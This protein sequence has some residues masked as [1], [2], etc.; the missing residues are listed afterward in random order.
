MIKNILVSK[1]FRGSLIVML[2]SVLVNI[3]NYLYHLFMGRL[4]GPV[5]Y[6][7][8]SSLI[9]LTYFLGVPAGAMNLQI[10]KYV[11]QEKGDKNKIFSFYL[12]FIKKLFIVS[13]VIFTLLLVATPWFSGVLKA[14]T[15][16]LAIIV[17]ISSFLSIFVSFNQS[18]FQ[19]LFQFSW[20]SLTGVSQYGSKL[21]VGVIL[22]LLGTRI[23][24]AVFSLFISALIA[25][26]LSSLIL[27][28]EA[29]KAKVRINRSI[30][31][32][33]IIS[34]IVP[35]LLF[36]LSFTSLYSVDIILARYFLPA[37]ESG[38]YSALSVMGKSMFFAITPFASVM[39]PLV[40]RKQAEKKNY[41]NVFVFSFVAVLA[42]CVAIVIAY[43]LTPEF[44]INIFY[45]V[46]Y[47]PI[48]QYLSIFA[49]IF[50]FFSLAHLLMNY[51]FSINKTKVVA[52]Y[53]I[54]AVAQAIGFFIMHDSIIQFAQ[55]SLFVV[56]FLF[57]ALSLQYLANEKKKL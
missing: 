55:V 22:V 19:G 53:V 9:A 7:L 4:L 5:D 3:S 32:K 54:A 17:I 41:R 6:G 37:I 46:K 28:N 29:K 2:G 10:V 52:F 44:F 51:F 56:F 30:R 27:L 49:Y 21:L 33:R 11:S 8:L 18:V 26:L 1:F 34:Y 40:S 43:T 36:N 16:W 25:L 12:W 39:F 15:P 45:G 20:F 57:V 48:G 35:A 31:S 42:V 23:F 38:Y 13:L 50:L 14:T 24:G 47:L